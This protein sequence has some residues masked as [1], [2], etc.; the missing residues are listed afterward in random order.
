ML[1]QGK[2]SSGKKKGIPHPHLPPPPP[3][4]ISIDSW[5]LIF[6]IV[7]NLLLYQIILM[8]KLLH[9]WP[10]R[11]PL[12][13]IFSTYDIS[14]QLIEYVFPFWYNKMFQAYLT[15]TILP[16]WISHFYEEPWKPMLEIQ[17]WEKQCWIWWLWKL[18]RRQF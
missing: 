12:R 16:S 17:I 18:P 14:H 11:A 9:I 13:W 2:P 1:P 7:Y 5:I 4:L 8:F 15:P 3:S 10:V 6:S